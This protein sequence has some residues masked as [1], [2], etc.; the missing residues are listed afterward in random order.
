MQFWA[1]GS[2][3]LL[4]GNVRTSAV[5]SGLILSHACGRLVRRFVGRLIGRLV[6]VTVL[7]TVSAVGTVVLH[8]CIF[9]HFC[10]HS[11]VLRTPS[12]M[13]FAYCKNIMRRF[14][15]K[16]TFSFCMAENTFLFIFVSRIFFVSSALTCGTDVLTYFESFELSPVRPS[17]ALTLP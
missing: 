6:F 1:S 9:C 12:H 10:L 2:N 16:Y 17:S 13:I 8:V 11:G 3:S 5:L 14:L 7:I 15:R 4:S